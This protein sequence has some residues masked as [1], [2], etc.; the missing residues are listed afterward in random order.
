MLSQTRKSQRA[1]CCSHLGEFSSLTLFRSLVCLLPESSPLL[2]P[3]HSPPQGIHPLS[4][5]FL[6][7]MLNSRAEYDLLNLV[8]ALPSMM[9]G[10]GNSFA[11]PNSI[12]KQTAESHGHFF[13]SRWVRNV[14]W[15]VFVEIHFSFKNSSFVTSYL[16]EEYSNWL[17][18]P[19][20]VPWIHFWIFSSLLSMLVTVGL[21][22]IILAINF[23]CFT[24]HDCF[25][26]NVIQIL[27]KNRV[28]TK[29]LPNSCFLLSVIITLFFCKCLII[30]LSRWK[31]V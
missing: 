1:C 28:C 26:L 23:N 11:L 6:Y 4:W 21:G 13:L 12:S 22:D 25:P 7:L 2:D 14:F 30:T 27:G 24:L 17:C 15:M 19:S 8:S 5:L 16:C 29:Q 3:L 20:P 31:D 10:I 18:H 9:A